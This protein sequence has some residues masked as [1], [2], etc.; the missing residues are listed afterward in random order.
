MHPTRLRQL[1]LLL[2]LSLSL[3]MLGCMSYRRHVKYPPGCRQTGLDYNIDVGPANG[4][5]K[6][7]ACVRKEQKIHWR[8]VGSDKGF[9]IH[10]IDPK[11][12]I[13]PIDQ[14]CK[15][16][17][18]AEILP[19]AEKGSAWRYTVT[20]TITGQSYDPVIIIDTCC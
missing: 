12:P 6:D 8:R 5:S 7:T 13:R 4:V 15:N 16:E 19:E 20:D 18:R 11:T 14:D 10:F 1:A 2:F 17:C 3:I 9:R